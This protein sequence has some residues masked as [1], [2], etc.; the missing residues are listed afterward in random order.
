MVQQRHASGFIEPCLPS[1]DATADQP[2]LVVIA[3][4][5]LLAV[6]LALWMG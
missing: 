2:S 3:F 1:K 4:R 6:L 5:L